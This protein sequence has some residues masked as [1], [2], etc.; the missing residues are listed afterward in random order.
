MFYYSPLALHKKEEPQFEMK[1]TQVRIENFRCFRDE[2]LSLNDYTCLVGANGCGKSTVLAALRIFFGDNATSTGD[3]LRLQEEDFHN[4]DT[5]KEVT[6]TLT[7]SELETEAENDFKHYVRHGQLV[8]S[9]VASWNA[10]ARIA[11]IK[12]FGQ[13]LIMKPFADFFRA[14]GDGALVLELKTIYAKIREST[15]ELPPPGSK[16]AMKDA[17]SAFESSHPEQCELD[18]SEDQ[19]YGFTKGSNLLKKYVEWVFVPAVK[20]ASTEQLE[21]KKTA[22]GL[23]LERTVRSK[24]SFADSLKALRADVEKQYQELLTQNQ[25]ALEALSKSLCTRLQDWA[26][27]DAFLA[28]MWRNDPSKNIAIQEPQAE[29]RAGEGLFQ[30]GSLT[31]FGHGLQRSFLLALLQELSG[32]GDTGNPRLLLAC[33]EP[34]LYQHPPQARHLSSVLQKLSNSNSQV[35]V[36]THSPHF[37]SGRGFEDVRL[38]RRDLMDDQPMA[39]SASMEDLSKCLA[40]ALGQKVPLPTGVELKIDQVL[41]PALNEM[42][43]TPVLILVEG[44]EDLG[45][46]SASM[47]LTGRY[48]EFRRLGCHIV[49]TL[50]KGNMVYTLAIAKLLEI[51]TFVVFDADGDKVG[52]PNQAQHER[53]NTAL[54]RLCGVP[55]ASPFPAAVFGTSSLVAWPTRIGDAVRDDLGAAAWQKY[56]A[57]ARKKRAVIGVPD[58]GKNALFIGSILTAAHEDAKGSKILEGVCNQIISFARSVRAGP[59]AGKAQQAAPNA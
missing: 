29:V 7:F 36:S 28:L 19:F 6:I 11:E 37:V 33:E 26:H 18:R 21:A 5:S 23:L 1:L 8:V 3:L 13:R 41:Q 40:E 4:R 14:D 35:I 12:Q 38:L 2:T 47:T 15:Q 25:G 52:T 46:I 34:E 42:F 27:P 22:L 49:P 54:L 24:M 48:E 10:V 59:S 56:E 9:A 44:A 32:C 53:D 31:R 17:L 57:L 58:L 39:R 20:D 50:G 55:K 45:Y 43:F 16:T 51:P 30:G